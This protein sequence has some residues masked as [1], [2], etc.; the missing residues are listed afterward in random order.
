MSGFIGREGY[1]FVFLDSATPRFEKWSPDGYVVKSE[2]KSMKSP[3]N[4]ELWGR[5]RVC[6]LTSKAQPHACD[7]YFEV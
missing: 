2:Q 1:D 5:Y 7:L 3:N 4:F 6:S